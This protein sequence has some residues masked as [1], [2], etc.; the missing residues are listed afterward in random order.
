MA[1]FVS[2]YFV[3]S[4]VRLVRDRPAVSGAGG[5][6][7]SL[8][9]GIREV[10][11]VA[12]SVLKRSPSKP[13]ADSAAPGLDDQDASDVQDYEEA[14]ET[15]ETVD[16]VES[17]PSRVDMTQ[18]KS[19]HP[20]NV[21]S[22]PS[23][24]KNLATL[25]IEGKPL[26]LFKLM[27]T[28]TLKSVNHENICCINTAVLI[29]LFEHKRY[30]IYFTA[31]AFSFMLCLI[32]GN[33]PRL[34]SEVRELSKHY[35]VC[36]CKSSSSDQTRSRPSSHIV[37]ADDSLAGATPPANES[38]G[39]PQGTQ[40]TGKR[41]PSAH[42]ASAREGCLFC[43]PYRRPS[44]V[45]FIATTSLGSDDD[46]GLISED[47]N[48]TDDCNVCYNFRQLL[49]YWNEYYLRRGRDRLSLEFSSHISFHVWK[50]VVGKF[51]YA[52]FHNPSFN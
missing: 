5:L 39:A 37:S 9:N 50:N 12:S 21:D 43:K 16:V 46:I 33:L 26:I 2:I 18:A 29:M 11:Q 52:L 30:L 38:E 8:G 1:V 42:H 40:S 4:A 20:L 49:W 3:P 32:R 14:L 51:C 19:S 31:L 45:D 24:M 44:K 27:V 34:L 47:L 22:F 6:I 25:L 35:G 13:N 17:V 28:V 7:Y 41:G 36:T 23:G 10:I 15:A 48:S